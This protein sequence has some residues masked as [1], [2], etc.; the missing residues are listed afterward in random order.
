MKIKHIII[1]TIEKKVGMPR[2]I[3]YSEHG[4]DVPDNTIDKQIGKEE[5]DR[6]FDKI[7]NIEDQKILDDYLGFLEHE[8]REIASRLSNLSEK[9]TFVLTVISIL[10]GSNMILSPQVV[11]KN[12]ILSS[13][14]NTIFGIIYFLSS[15]GLVI[16]FCWFLLMYRKKTDYQLIDEFKLTDIIAFYRNILDYKKEKAKI[17]LNII[18]SNYETF[19]KRKKEVKCLILPIAICSVGIAISALIIIFHTPEVDNMIIH[20]VKSFL[21]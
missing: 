3:Q 14:L 2:K 1:H 21:S 17:L 19:E 18:H 15:I 13:T 5:I 16:V 10:L 11:I 9:Y 12:N 7:D 6:N 20:A 8:Y 4:T